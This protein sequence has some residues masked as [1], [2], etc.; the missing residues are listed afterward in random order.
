MKETIL[1]NLVACLMSARLYLYSENWAD[2]GLAVLFGLAFII[3]FAKFL[4]SAR[5]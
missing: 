4:W 3:G 2:A 1:P 5:P